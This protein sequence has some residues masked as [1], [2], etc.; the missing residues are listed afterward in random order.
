MPVSGKTV[1]FFIIHL[2]IFGSFVSRARDACYNSMS[3][4]LL[5]NFLFSC[6]VPDLLMCNIGPHKI[7]KEYI[8]VDVHRELLTNAHA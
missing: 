6:A 1:S 5:N 2:C 8:K 3:C 4:S 7:M